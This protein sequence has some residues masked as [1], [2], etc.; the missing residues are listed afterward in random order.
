VK[1][2]IS[3]DSDTLNAAVARWLVEYIREVLSTHNRFTIALSGGSTPKGLYRLLRTPEYS[4]Q[5]NWK[6]MHFFW[7][8]E[9]VVPYS[10]EKNNARMAFDELLSIV[11]VVKNQIH[12]IPTDIEPLES[13][14]SYDQLLH[15][16]FDKQLY[17]FDLVLLGLG[18]NSHTLSLFPG[19]SE[20]IFEKQEWVRS[21]WL[22]DQQM[23]R[24]TLTAPVVNKAGRVAFLVSGADKAG[25]TEAVISGKFDPLRHPA[26]II[27]PLNDELYWFLDQPA[28][29]GLNHSL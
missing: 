29:S 22:E 21:L 11:P 7:G 2:N 16:Y 17:T 20:P 28:A 8:D 3:N 19:H 18:D 27:R 24:I 5:I 1:V 4:S 10:D 9:R 14:R 6:Q 12:P 15:Q 23:H 13:A 26:Q 25:A